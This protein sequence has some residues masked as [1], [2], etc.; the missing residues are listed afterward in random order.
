M[1]YR[2]FTHLIVVFSAAILLLPGHLLAVEPPP[3]GGYFNGNTAEGKDALF[4]LTLS[5]GSHTAVGFHTLY[6]IPGNSSNTAIGASVLARTTNT[7]GPNT[8]AGFQA[9]LKVDKSDINSAVGTNTLMN[10]T[11]DYFENQAIGTNALSRATD[12]VGVSAFGSGA[13]EVADAGN[14]VAFG[15]RAQGLSK[16][17]GFNVALGSNSLLKAS[18]YFNVALGT[19]AL[20]RLHDDSHDV[21]AIGYN[22]GLHLTNDATGDINI[23]NEGRRGDKQTIRIGTRNT[24]G[25]FLAGVSGVTVPLGVGVVTNCEAQL[26]TM[27]SSA[28]YKTRIRSLAEDSQ[29]LYQLKPVTFRYKKALDPAGRLQFGLVAEQVARVAPELVAY[30]EQHRP[31]S[32]RYQ[33]VNTLLLNEF[34][35]DKRTLQKEDKVLRAADGELM[36]LNVR[37]AQL[38]KKLAEQTIALHTL[39]AQAALT[40]TN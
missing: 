22:A 12:P 15:F 27:T 7:Y 3:D 30:D 13:L 8:A 10:D 5:G 18:G 21:I 36:Q 38:Q 23:G 17:S 31:Y 32:V 9:M 6:S 33:A 24:R 20:G 4:H 16:S 37:V 34:L 2:S 14:S 11:G 26:G 25:T 19:N 39:N 1:T 40:Q 29:V 28:S 35:R